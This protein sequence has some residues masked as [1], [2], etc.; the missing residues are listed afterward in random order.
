[1]FPSSISLSLS[2]SLSLSFPDRY[3][4]RSSDMVK[5]R[6]I[7]RGDRPTDRPKSPSPPSKSRSQRDYL[8][9]VACIKRE[10]DAKS[11][12]A[13]GV[14]ISICAAKNKLSC[15]SKMPPN[16]DLFIVAEKPLSWRRILPSCRAHLQDRVILFLLLLV[17]TCARKGVSFCLSAAEAAASAVVD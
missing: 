4:E 7:Q 3:E 1:M 15:R 9:R 12:A 2:L 8:R 16:S 11:S 10:R 14:G 6:Q 17:Y 13:S 5:L